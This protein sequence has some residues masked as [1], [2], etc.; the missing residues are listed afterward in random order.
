MGNPHGG[1]Y[2]K[3][4]CPSTASTVAGESVNADADLQ[5]NN[6]LNLVSEIWLTKAGLHQ[7][8]DEEANECYTFQ[9]LWDE[10]NR[11]GDYE[12]YFNSMHSYQEDIIIEHLKKNVNRNIIQGA[13]KTLDEAGDKWNRLYFLDF[14]IKQ[15]TAGV[16]GMKDCITELSKTFPN[17][18]LIK[19]SNRFGIHVVLAANN[20]YYN[21]AEH[22]YYAFIAHR[23]VCRYNPV[24]KEAE[25]YKQVMDPAFFNSFNQRMNMN[26]FSFYGGNRY[27]IKDFAAFNLTPKPYSILIQN[28]DEYA[29]ILSD[30][31]RSVVDKY[32]YKM[33]GS[34]KKSIS[35]CSTKISAIP[36]TGSR[37]NVDRHFCLPGVEYSGN[38]L[39]WRIVATL[40]NEVGYDEAKAIISSS[41]VQVNE[42]LSA[43]DTICKDST[44]KY[45]FTNYLI[46]QYVRKFILDPITAPQPIYLSQD[47]YL[48]DHIKLIEDRLHQGSVYLVSS[49]NTGKT[50]LIKKLVRRFDK[51]IIIVPQHS[52]LASKFETSEFLKRFIIKTQDVNKLSYLPSTIICIWDTFEKLSRKYDLS[53]YYLFLDE[54]HNFI[55]QFGFRDVIMR[56]L[57]SLKKIPHQLWLTGTP[58]GEEDLMGKHVRIDFEKQAA[59]K[60]NVYPIQLQT[61]SYSRYLGC[62][63]GFL[64]KEIQ[65][66]RRVFVYDNYCHNIWT[67]YLKGHAAHYVSI[68][69]D[70]DDVKE[71]DQ[72]CK[73]SKEVVVN[74]SYL[75]EGV[76]IKGYQEVDLLIPTNR[77]ISEVN[78]RQF[79]KRFRDAAV[80]NVY[81]VQY[82]DTID[83]QMPYKEE[84]I[85][86]YTDYVKGLSQS[87][88]EQNPII[89]KALQISHLKRKYIKMIGSDSRYQRLYNAFFRYMSTPFNIYLAY[90]LRRGVDTVAVNSIESL[91]VDA[92]ETDSP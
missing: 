46:E 53:E 58:C 80:V 81:L 9:R 25:L 11:M 74:T 36:V 48:S 60:Y 75:G 65:Y 91:L 63:M 16:Q 73:S 2:S 24:F 32:S 85:K 31:E 14:D 1:I 5:V 68:Y 22:L 29:C 87:R 49:P 88:N 4:I 76:D 54:V 90:S 6:N 82:T 56:V 78:V 83:N 77:F 10:I 30:E 13:G 28:F 62:V 17:H 8:R 59:T 40:F 66:K 79:I 19:P 61:N 89:D 12:E 42:M 51:C 57:E 37:I 47:E 52:I 15:W 84:E 67:N 35:T 70:S 92:E 3:E 44:G 20:Q 69:K 18:I 34:R 7:T 41:F 27:M 38:A 64:N 71:I 43:L 21:P 39:R 72:T 45:Q 86:M 26:I 23:I 50:E 55:V 33:Y